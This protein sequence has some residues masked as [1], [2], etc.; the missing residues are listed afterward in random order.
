MM[1]NRGF[2][3]SGNWMGHGFWLNGWSWLIIIGFLLIVV[4]VTYLLVKKNKKIDT[5]SEALE[6][7]K[8][9]YAK[10]EIT[11]EEYVNRKNVLERYRRKS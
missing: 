5:S 2:F 3:Q 4:A 10:G 9:K 8:F 1:Y 6:I 11:E 7:L